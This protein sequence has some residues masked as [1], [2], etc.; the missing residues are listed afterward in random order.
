MLMLAAPGMARAQTPDSAV[1]L[2]MGISPQVTHTLSLWYREFETESLGCLYGTVNL[3]DTI[4]VILLVPADVRPI[5]STANTVTPN[6]RCDNG[7]GALLGEVHSHPRDGA[8]LHGRRFRITEEELC[9]ASPQDLVSFIEDGYLL[10]MISCGQDR[11][12]LYLRGATETRHLCTFNP[13]D[14]IP[15]CE[16]TK[17]RQLQKSKGFLGSGFSSP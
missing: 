11:L 8:D 14:F 16:W 7:Y 12:A 10:L 5:R 4:M 13:R 3:P 6:S 17:E 2:A 1:N 9:F 15:R